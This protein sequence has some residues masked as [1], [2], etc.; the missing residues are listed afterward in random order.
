MTATKIISA[1][2][3]QKNTIHCLIFNFL[4]D[5]LTTHTKG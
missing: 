5:D 2:F 4:T 3:A 1:I